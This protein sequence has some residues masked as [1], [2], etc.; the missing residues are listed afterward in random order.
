METPA[1]FQ[2]S[3]QM[4][5]PNLERFLVC[6]LG[7]LGQCCVVALKKFGVNVIAIELVKPDRWEIANLPDLLD[8]LIIGDCSENS[9]LEAAQIQS[10]R[11]ALL[12]TSNEGVNI[13]TAL[14]IRQLNP[15]TRLVVRSA[16]ENLNYLLTQQISNFIAYESTQLSA[17]AFAL[18]AF[19][20]EIIGLFKLDDKKFQIVRRCI[21]YQKRD[22]DANISY[23]G[24][25]LYDLI[26][27]KRQILTHSR[28]GEPLC[29]SFYQWNLE[30]IVDLGD[31]LVCLEIVEQHS[32]QFDADAD[33]FWQQQIPPRRSMVARSLGYS[34]KLLDRFFRDNRFFRED[35]AN[36]I[37]QFWQFSFQQRVR[38]IVIIYCFILLLLLPIGTILFHTYYP[39]I[40]WLS[41]F[42]ITAI[43]LLGGYGD[44]FGN[45]SPPVPLPWWLQLFSLLLAL[46]GTAFVGV[47]YALITEAL[48]SVRF[49]FVK[50]RP[51]IPP[52][53][54]IAIVGMDRIGQQVATLL[55]EFQ[56]PLVAIT[57]HSS[58]ERE[59][60]MQI[61][62]IVGNIKEALTKANLSKAK[63]MA[64][65]TDDEILNLEVALMARSLA[66]NLNLVIRTCQ[67]HLNERFSS[68]L[69][70]AQVLF[71]DATA[72]EVFVGAAFGEKI[73]NLF[74]LNNQTILVTE[75][76]VESGDTL[77]DLLISEVACGYGVIP[78]LH[79][80]F[81]QSAVFFPSEDLKLSAGDRLVVLATI[82]ALQRVERGATSM[83]PKQTL[84]RIDKAL[85]PDALFDGANTIARI[86]GC[87]LSLAHNLMNSL[88]QTLPLPLY[89]HQAQRLVRELRKIFV[90]ARIVI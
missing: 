57:F 68:F 20:S 17:T 16:K 84:V 19:D 67:Q 13:E 65:L 23:L 36:R 86:S 38:Q 51:Q 1:S 69:P 72:A 33:S 7:S 30:E 44:V 56:Q 29:S 55:Q 80:K 43:L 42:S 66:P 21:D 53:N 5:P 4:S 47:L 74:H 89:K 49:Q 77:N 9:I 45:L 6:G 50:R 81:P 15:H 54:H 60:L 62:I 70:N 61:P 10:C 27:Q 39:N 63:S 48:L 58:F 34:L 26:S 31:T 88:P 71:P 28:H 46:V 87:R 85:T 82:D 11:V 12:V 59:T 8:E 35:I 64:I 90:Q 2:Q 24:R 14:A 76:R 18:A 83:Y 41:G 25:S 73:I 37:Y 75:Y 32:L 52:Q 79:Q 3:A 40:S 78:V 22:R